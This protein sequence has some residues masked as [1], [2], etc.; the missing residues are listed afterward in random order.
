MPL[1]FKRN[2]ALLR[3]V[4]SIEE[5][6]TLLEWLQKKTQPKIDLSGCSH[7]HPAN[8]Q[9]LLAA[10]VTIVAWPADAAFAGWLQ[11]VLNP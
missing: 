5:A 2:V 1:E 9:L 6:E 4:V 3:E 11:S 10:Q 8:L 7:L